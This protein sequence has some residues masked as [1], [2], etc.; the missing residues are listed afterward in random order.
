ME[1]YSQTGKHTCASPGPLKRCTPLIGPSLLA[2]TFDRYLL[3][4]DL[5]AVPMEMLWP[6]H[7][8]D[9][10]HGGLACGLLE[11]L[12]VLD[13]SHSVL[14]VRLRIPPLR[15]TTFF[16]SVSTFTRFLPVLSKVAV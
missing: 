13:P 4:V 10:F 9:R 5:P 11:Q 7:D 8:K 1:P 12:Y 2:L 14:S 6:G 3:V 15:E 16:L